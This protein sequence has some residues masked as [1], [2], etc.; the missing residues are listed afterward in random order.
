M[1]NYYHHT[2]NV[3]G[4]DKSSTTAINDIEWTEGDGEGLFSF[5]SF[6]FTNAGA[7]GRTGPSLSTALAN[8]NTATYT[9][10]NDTAYFNIVDQ[11]IQE[12][13]VP[14]TADYT[15]EVIGAEGGQSTNTGATPGGGG[16]PARMIGTFG[17]TQGDVV[18]IAV[19]QA[20]RGGS[21]WD[22][23][24]PGGGGGTFVWIN[25]PP[26]DPLIIAGG[27]GGRRG[28]QGST[29]NVNA[30]SGQDAGL[31][32]GSN[33]ANQADT[34]MPGQVVAQGHGSYRQNTRYS[35]SGGGA[36]WLNEGNCSTRSN[37]GGTSPEKQNSASS[38]GSYGLFGRDLRLISTR[39][40]GNRMYD[41]TNVEV[42]QTQKLWGGWGSCGAGQTDS[43][44][45]GFG[46]GGGGGCGGEGGGA[47]YTGGGATWG[48]NDHGGGGG[49][50]NGGSNQSNTAGYTGHSSVH[51]ACIITKL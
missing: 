44:T 48:A 22:R 26:S 3:I 6:T 8:Y 24:D 40:D 16:N 51:G 49:S 15:I 19:G 21:G 10:L 46:G 45:G 20:G 43:H 39:N 36:G 30:Q 1:A 13:T 27:G 42:S 28:T 33:L 41:Y 14:E 2:S 17:L 50:Y 34:S 37:Q 4:A 29:A 38:C 25:D 32:Y 47:G 12:F 11:G 5:T 35:C 31:A 9:W 18:K 23:A 7:E